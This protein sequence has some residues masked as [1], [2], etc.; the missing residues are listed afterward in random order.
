MMQ[1]IAVKSF[2][3]DNNVLKNEWTQNEEEN[4][5]DMGSFDG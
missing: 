3:L 2:F 4:I 1:M 5:I